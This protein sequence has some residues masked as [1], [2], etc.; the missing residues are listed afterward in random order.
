[1]PGAHLPACTLQACSSMRGATGAWNAGLEW[2]S[3]LLALA[4]H[5]ESVLRPFAKA[6][7]LLRAAVLACRFEGEYQ[8]NKVRRLRAQAAG[9]GGTQNQFAGSTALQRSAP[10]PLQPPL[11][12]PPSQPKQMDG[13]GV[14]V[15][16]DGTIYRGQWQNSMMH[17]CGVKISKQPNG[18]EALAGRPARPCTPVGQ[19]V[20]GRRESFSEAWLR[21]AKLNARA[22]SSCPA[23]RPNS[24]TLPPLPAPQA[25][26]WRRRGSS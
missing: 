6:P 1:M 4:L 9:G 19:Q 3:S 25:T 10:A 24:S 18:G 12:P 15:W 23:S 14:Y 8:E 7:S 11:R 16:R 20:C 26:S 22:S 2:P 21:D 13:F 5:V 17:G